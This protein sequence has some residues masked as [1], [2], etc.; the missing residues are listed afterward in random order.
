MNI[1]KKEISAK[2]IIFS[3]IVD[4]KKVGRSYLYLMHNDLHQ[5]PFGLIEDVYVNESFRGQKIGTKLIEAMILEAKIRD[6]Y[7]LIMTSRYNRPKVHELYYKLS[8][9]DWGKEFRLN[10]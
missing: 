4:G 1:Q 8:F 3:A 9:T 10:L 2:G 7:K 6:C 5:R